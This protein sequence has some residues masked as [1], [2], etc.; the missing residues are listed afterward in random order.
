MH[1]FKSIF[2]R[3]S[4]K[5]LRYHP[6]LISPVLFILCLIPSSGLTKDSLRRSPVV[7][8]VER[9]S[10]AVVNISTLIRERVRSPFPFA[11]DDFFR[12]FFP[13]L[14][15]REYTRTSLGSGVVVDGKNGHIVTNHHVVT[16]ATEIKVITSTQKELRAKIV[17]SD[18]R[19]DLAVLK[20]E[21]EEAL[22]EVEMGDS[23]R[24]MI[25]ETVIAIGNPFGLSQTVTTGV[26]SALDRTV[27]TEDRV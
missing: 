1:R 7:I 10:P 3:Q 27:R 11:G 14:F 17:G 6:S 22:P 26:V 16:R 13:E 4:G 8:A 18:P 20:V 2:D 24:I 5:R 21:A 15:S 19:S 25:G 12:D 9:V 23:D